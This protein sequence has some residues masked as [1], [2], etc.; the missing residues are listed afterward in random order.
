VLRQNT[1]LQHL[2]LRG[3]GLRSA[4]LAEIAPALYRNTSIKSL[5]L[6]SNCLDDIESA[7]VLRELIR[8]NRT[9]T[10]LCLAVNFFGSNAAATLIIVEGV[11]SN[12][13]LQKLDL[14][15]CELCDHGILILANALAIRN[16]SML[17]LDLYC[18]DI[19]SVGVRALV[20][21]NVEVVKTLINLRLTG[22]RIRCEGATMLANALRDNAMPSLKQLQL[23][24]CGI[25]DDGLVA[26]VLALEQDTG[27]HILDL[28]GNHFGERGFVALAESLPNMKGLQQIK[29]PVANMSFRSTLPLLL[30]SFRKNTSLVEVES[31][32]LHGEWPQELKFFGQRNRFTPLLKSSDPPGVPPQQRFGIWSLAL[33]KVATEPDVLF[34]VLCNKPKLVRSHADDVDSKNKRK[35]DD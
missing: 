27:L 3:N 4:G 33:A 16:A 8:R 17:E 6:G 2:S 28:D 11:R 18:N 25:G 32:Y 24:G 30:E 26:L 31:D 9:I 5:D 35:R 10:R 29:M 22:N 12:K 7:N 20:D 21:D 19:T 15:S 23:Y 1:A 13:A 14:G 34:H